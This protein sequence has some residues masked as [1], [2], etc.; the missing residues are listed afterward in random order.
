MVYAVAFRQLGNAQQAEDATQQTFVQ[1]WKA[2]GS[3]DPT[4]EV[5]PWLAVIAKRVAIDIYRSEARRVHGDIDELR[6]VGVGD[7]TERLHRVWSVRAALDQLPPADRELIR[8]LHVEGYAQQEV[9]DRLGIPV[10]TVKSRSFK[11]HQ[12]FVAAFTSGEPNH[13]VAPYSPVMSSREE[14]PE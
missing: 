5:G 6:D 2:A 14:V 11:A 9:A 4:R 13:P 3:I 12:R 10:G 8:L 1:A 7:D